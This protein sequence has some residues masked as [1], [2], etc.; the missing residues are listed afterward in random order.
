MTLTD[1][2]KGAV[3]MLKNI[4]I[5]LSGSVGS[6]KSTIGKLLSEKLNV[7]FISVG[8][9]SRKK[10]E[11]MGMDIDQF[12]VYLKKHPEMDREMDKYIIE[13]M[14]GKTNFILDYRLGFHF[15]KNSFNVLLK[16]SPE[17][18]L[19]RVSGRVGTNEFYD[20]LGLEQKITKMN[21]RNLN[22]QT[23]FLELYQVDFLSEKNYDLVL[24]TDE[25]EPQEITSK[26]ITQLKQT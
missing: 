13:E 23:R 24:E 3:C 16:V 10:A 22:M 1:L 17:L 21:A 25:L 6:G 2:L 9:L 26:I 4:K 8:N 12:Q 5:T 19:K 14:E 15:I 11:L 20:G 7:E 18:A